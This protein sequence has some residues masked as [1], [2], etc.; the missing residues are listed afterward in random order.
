M[1]SGPVH[2]EKP[3]EEMKN[4]KLLGTIDPATY[5]QKSLV[6]SSDGRHAI[7]LQQSKNRH[8][9]LL[10]GV[11][12]PLFEGTFRPPA[13]LSPDGRRV[14]Y[15]VENEKDRFQLII[16]D[17]T[18]GPV[19][20]KIF[21]GP[22]F[23]PDSRRIAYAGVLKGEY[24]VLL[25]G[26]PGPKYELV[27]HLNFS[28]DS[29]HFVYA[30]QQNKKRFI[31][32]DGV[33]GPPFDD[34]YPSGFSPDGRHLVYYATQ[35]KKYHIMVDDHPGPEYD[36]IGPVRFNPVQG[37]EGPTIGYIGVLGSKLIEVTQSMP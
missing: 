8:Q 16:T 24:Q 6:F 13:I 29:R 32:V 5:V 12:G 23:S 21:T 18:F 20:D 9:L 37:H 14:A 3:K 22:V 25:D 2:A 15:L 36:S 35:G 33:P 27:G 26:V 10:D 31:V 1:P 30:A 11:P 34:V 17:G 4:G 7:W 19:F 28:P